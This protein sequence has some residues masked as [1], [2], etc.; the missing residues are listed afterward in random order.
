MLPWASISRARCAGTGLTRPP[1]AGLGATRSASP[2]ASS[3]PAGSPVACRICDSLARPV[4]IGAVWLAGRSRAM[5]SVT[6][7]RAASS[8]SRWYSTSA[9]PVY[10][11]P[12]AGEVNLAQ[13]VADR[14]RPAVLAGRPPPGDAGGQAALSVVEPTAEPVGQGQLQLAHRGQQP[15]AVG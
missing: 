15:V 13:I 4:A 7:R 3:A 6:C 10:A 11:M 12:A 1:T 9:M 2:I 5:P 8:S 14:D